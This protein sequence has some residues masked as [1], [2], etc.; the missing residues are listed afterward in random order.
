MNSSKQLFEDAPVPK[1]VFTMAIPMILSMLVVVIY[2]MADTFFVGQLGDANQVAA[3]SVATPVFMLLMAIGNMFGIGGSSYISRL[4]GMKQ[5]EKAK[6]VSSFCFYAGII[7]GIIMLIV[8]LV[9]MEPIL[10]LI[11]CSNQTKGF[12]KTYL[13]YVAFGSSIVIVSNALSNIIR[14][15]GAAKEAMFGMMLGTITNIILD[16]IMILVMK[17]GVA[18]AAI[19][20]IIGNLLSL[21]YYVY[22]FVKKAKILSI[23]LSDFKA[24]DRIS[25]EV[26]AIGL[27]ASLNNVLMSFSNIVL[28]NFLAH[29]GDTAVAS[30]GVAMKANILVVLLQIGFAVGIQP[31]IGYCFGA[32]N[33]TRL[34][35]IV[36]FSLISE[37]ILGSLLTGLYFII[38]GNI[39]KAFINDTDVITLGTKMLKVLMISGPVIGILFVCTNAL[40]AMGRALA[41]LILSISRQGFVFIPTLIILNKLLQLDGLIYAQTV[42]DFFS[43]V[44]AVFMFAFIVH[45]NEKK[46]LLKKQQMIV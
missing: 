14:A 9:A 36:K 45:K 33:F 18:G 41:S 11:G 32:R 24:N 19:A 4:L 20:T 2:N 28:N 13:S 25:T 7:A 26:F 43:I 38:G 34:K 40:Q 17:M 35:A 44:T 12:A 1:A 23:K 10:K 6:H 39:V 3:V 31:L 15:E 30:M 8:F 5:E 42:A 16:P 37:V 21:L 27:P 22:F 29:Y 46:D